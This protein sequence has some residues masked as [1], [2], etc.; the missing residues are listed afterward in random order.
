MPDNADDREVKRLRS[1]EKLGALDTPPDPAL[2]RIC[3]LVELVFSCETVLVSLVDDSRQW[4]KRKSG[5]VAVDETPREWSFCTHAIQ[6]EG[7]LE[8]I[9][10]LIDPVFKESP[11]VT[12][13]PRI[14]Y[15][16]GAPIKLSDGT[17][18]GTLCLIDLKPRTPLADH[19]RV[20]L[21]EFAGLVGRELELNR[22]LRTALAQMGAV[23]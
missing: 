23:P 15:Y 3:R 7:I 12:G 9:D 2:E 5:A 11:L 20:M 10:A 6:E 16:A 14:R 4:F 13:P 17:L 19:E 22:A 18:P 21:S 8:V 1:L